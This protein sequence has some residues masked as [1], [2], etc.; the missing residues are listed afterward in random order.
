MRLHIDF[1][2]TRDRE[3]LYAHQIVLQLLTSLECQAAMTE[4]GLAPAGAC[5]GAG[6]LDE[7]LAARPRRSTP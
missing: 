5:R 1:E 6:R 2:F 7:I 3:V 4:A